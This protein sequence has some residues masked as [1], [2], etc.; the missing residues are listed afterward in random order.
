[1]SRVMIVDG[2]ETDRSRIARELASDGHEVDDA[3]DGV[4]AFEKL[5]A[6]SCDVLVTEATL[7]RLALPE[8]I[9][10]LRGRGVKTPVLVLTGATR[11]SAISA[12]MKLDI[13]GCIAKAAPPNVLREKLAALLGSPRGGEHAPAPEP[14]A[15]VPG[16]PAPAGGVLVVDG[17]EEEQQRLRALLPPSLRVEVCA[18]IQDGLARGRGGTHRMILVDAD[19]AMVNLGGV[20]AQLHRLQ[21]EAA[22]VAIAKVGKGADELAVA[23]L[24]AELGFDDVLFRPFRPESV[25][26]LAEQ[27][28]SSWEDLV[29]TRD[30]VILVSPLR[31][32]ADQRE[33]YISELGARLM[34]AL[35]PLSEACYEYA[36]VDLTRASRLLLVTDAMTLIA[37]LERTAAA[38][39]ISLL[40]A[41]PDE[42]A[43][44]MSGID[45]SL[46]RQGFRW[47]TSVTAARASLG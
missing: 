10:R 31:R 24:V 47:F 6:L 43:A 36:L 2:N 14:A 13:A 7:D 25:A 4:E 20:I 35:S 34:A 37:Q 5:L 15:P 46:D 3:P 30:D 23:R 29:T 44:A 17:A 33:R 21:P 38:L 11:A 41:V 8:L 40:F 28:C 26:L 16:G 42:L 22:V 27:Y 12:V 19:A 39:G 18:R 1:M 9:A 32:R 45:E